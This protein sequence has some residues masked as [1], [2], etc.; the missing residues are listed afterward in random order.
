MHD[1]RCRALP[2]ARGGVRDRP[3]ERRRTGRRLGGPPNARLHPLIHRTRACIADL[4][5]GTSVPGALLGSR[6][7]SANVEIEPVTDEHHPV[8]VVPETPPGHRRAHGRDRRR[9]WGSHLRSRGRIVARNKR[10][11]PTQS[12]SSVRRIRTAVPASCDPQSASTSYRGT[13]TEKLSVLG[14]SQQYGPELPGTISHTTNGCW[15]FRIEY[16]THHRQDWD[17]CP[18]GEHPSGDRGPNVPELLVRRD[19]HRRPRALHLRPAG[20]RDPPQRGAR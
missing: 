11:S 16:S 15:T 1:E 19:D 8:A 20:R 4:E 6:P 5:V 10:R 12:R 17:Y 7:I 13:G 2:A 14:T 3:T 9:G 18:A